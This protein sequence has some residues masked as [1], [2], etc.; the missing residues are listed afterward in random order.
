M[1]MRRS[2]VE[3]GFSSEEKFQSWLDQ[4]DLDADI[5]SVERGNITL[6]LI[7]IYYIIIM[8][9]KCVLAVMD[10][11]IFKNIRKNIV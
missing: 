1:V 4:L 5:L 7:I 6:L 8:E 9:N 3:I 11:F 10:Q 2:S